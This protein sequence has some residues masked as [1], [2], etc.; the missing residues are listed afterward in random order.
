MAWATPISWTS[1]QVTSTILNAQIKA[2]EDVLS[3]HAHTNAA[4][5]G[6]SSMSG[7][8][9]SAVILPNLA[10]PVLADQA[11]NPGTAGRL[12][13]N[14][15]NLVYYDGTTLIGLY[16]DAPVGTPSLRTL[17][18]GATQAAAGDHTH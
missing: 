9:L 11:G 6:A 7:L 8:T 13:R 2:N 12:Q 15:Y 16:A 4:G 18:T 17:G 10:V 3:T 5:Q 14:G 1:S